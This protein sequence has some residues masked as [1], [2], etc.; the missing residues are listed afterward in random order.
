MGEM[1]SLFGMIDNIIKNVDGQVC[2]VMNVLS[3]NGFNFDLH[4]YEVF[5][6]SKVECILVNDLHSPFPVIICKWGNGSTFATMR[7][8][9]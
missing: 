2:L 1:L 5:E 4:A 3:T 9:L 8:S 7:H 6:T